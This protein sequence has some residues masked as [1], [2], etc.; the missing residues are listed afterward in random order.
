MREKILFGCLLFF[1]FYFHVSGFY[2]D[3]KINFTRKAATHERQICKKSLFHLYIKK[4]GSFAENKNLIRIE[5]RPGVGGEEALLWSRELLN[6]YKL[7]AQRINCGVKKFQDD[8]ECLVLSSHNNVDIIKDGREVK[9]NLY[10]LFKNES[11]IH[12]VK[13]IPR[14][15]S[16][17]KIHSST[18]TI[19]I[20]LHTYEERKCEINSK[21]LKITTF[22]SS[23]PGGQNVNKIESGVS[24]MHIPTGIQS[25]CQEERTQELN[26]RIAMKR[27]TLKIREFRNKENDHLL[28]SE[29]AKL[30]KDS[31]RSNRI[32]TYNFFRGY[33]T[34]H[35]TKRKL[36]LMYFEKVKLEYLLHI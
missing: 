4:E 33:I 15:E 35:I 11:G 7:F 13:R 23:K 3:Q 14:N 32:R 26:K 29:R 18:A 20:F 34:D 19:A 9:T 25:E 22:R 6:T 1:I 28:Q 36:N 27:L 21:D 31:N 8:S 10:D 17:D 30:I 16:K 2:I 12:Q 5:F 24:I